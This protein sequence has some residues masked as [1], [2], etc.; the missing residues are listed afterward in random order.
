METC[1]N[2]SHNWNTAIEGYKLFRRD[3]L[4]RGR[5]IALSVKEWMDCKGLPLGNTHE[6]VELVG[7]SQGLHQ[8][9]T[10]H[11]WGLIQVSG[12]GKPLDEDSCLSYRKHR[13]HK[14]SS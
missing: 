1:W 3:R 8:Q 14:L 2:E 13:T 11:G 6:Q 9:K 4:G 7:K 10:P 5:S 12:Q